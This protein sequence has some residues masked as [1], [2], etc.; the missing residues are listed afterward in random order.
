MRRRHR[1]LLV[2]LALAAAGL[3]TAASG[4]HASAITIRYASP[5]GTGVSGPCT[6]AAP[7]DLPTAIDQAPDGAE[8]IIE[9]GTY[10][11]STPLTASLTDPNGTLDIRGPA[12]GA[13]AVIY[14]NAS[15]GLYFSGSNVSNLTLMASPGGGTALLDFNG[16]VSHV[17]V[18]AATGTACSADHLLI[19]SLCVASDDHGSAIQLYVATG[20][21]TR[22][23]LTGVLRGDT[24]IATGAFGVGLEVSASGPATVTGTALNDIFHGGLYDVEVQTSL[25]TAV[26]SVSISHSDYV[27]RH[28][29]PTG[30]A[31]DGSAAITSD[32]TDLNVAPS[33]VDAAAGDYR[34]KAKS[35]TVNAGAKVPAGDS[36]LVG[37]PRAAGGTSDMGAYEFLHKPTVRRLTVAKQTDHS[38]RVSLTVNAEGL[39]TMLTV[40]ASHGRHHVS[41]TFASGSRAKAAVRHVVLRGL[42]PHTTYHLTVVASNAGGKSTT[43]HG[44][45]K[46]RRA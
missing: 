39:R 12:R 6:H 44:T 34:E 13:P 29:A 14:T 16:T 46:T 30:G 2:V 8:V 15:P 22:Q 36:D 32:N 24:G 4:T 37:N 25:S 11:K 27:T 45:L 21:P 40:R 41:K 20:G 5:T 18:D 35:V 26:A 43:I 31:P 9:P 17:I 3:T 19:D 33:F 38:A 42:K 28:I 1:E 7:C 10:D 23:T